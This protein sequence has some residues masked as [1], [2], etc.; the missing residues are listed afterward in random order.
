MPGK[1]PRFFSVALLLA[2]AG[3]IAATAP[4]IPSDFKYTALG[5]ELSFWTREGYRP[6]PDTRRATVAASIELAEA[7]PHRATYQALAAMALA[8]QA[9]LS[10]DPQVSKAAT[11]ESTRFSHRAKQL[12]PKG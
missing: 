7:H 11:E 2:A 9:R 5:T 10:F 12:R 8:G 3:V 4:K 6:T 1:A